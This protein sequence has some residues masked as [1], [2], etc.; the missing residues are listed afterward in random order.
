MY[1]IQAEINVTQFKPTTPDYNL[2]NSIQKM[3]SFVSMVFKLS[4]YDAWIQ[5]KC[6]QSQDQKVL[7]NFLRNNR[8]EKY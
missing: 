6:H 8:D 1:I 2:R 5:I 7:V 4:M 3:V